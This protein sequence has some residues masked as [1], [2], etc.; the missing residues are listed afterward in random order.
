MSRG[1]RRAGKPGKSTGGLDRLMVATVSEPA[2][3]KTLKFRIARGGMEYE[4]F[5]LRKGGEVYGYLNLC[6][7]WSVGLDLDD[8]DFFAEDGKFLMCK[9]HG[10]LYDPR[11]GVCLA[12]PCAGASLYRVPLEERDGMWCAKLDE[13]EW[14]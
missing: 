14:E 5:L 10:A 7:H 4:A 6:R 8:N 2:E 12:G 3:G 9:N 13:V 1:G 11:S